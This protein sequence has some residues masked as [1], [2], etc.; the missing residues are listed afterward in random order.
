MWKRSVRVGA[1]RQN[2]R[3]R[4][5]RG[6]TL[7]EM[8][9]LIIIIAVITAVAVPAYSRFYAHIKF[10]G[11][12]QQVMSL[13]AFA[14]DSAVQA[15]RDSTLQFDPGSETFAVAVDTP[16]PSPDQ[17]TALQDAANIESQQLVPPRT[18]TLGQDVGVVDFQVFQK[19]SSQ[20]N[21]NPQSG[22]NSQGAGN[23]TIHFHQDGSSDAANFTIAGQE[24]FRVDVEVS[25]LT[26]RARIKDEGEMNSMS[27]QRR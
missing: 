12:V 17:P 6:F 20:G 15:S 24:G 7:I 23:N 16:D 1:G 3:A 27:G 19:G 25:P 8:I 18:A 9:V 10:D 14:R 13:L 26:G 2:L 11:S 22:M 4:L 21:P 5:A